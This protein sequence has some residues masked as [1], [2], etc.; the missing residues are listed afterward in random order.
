MIG[1]LLLGAGS[2]M[3]SYELGWGRLIHYDEERARVIIEINFLK[4]AYQEGLQLWA[5]YNKS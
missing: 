3:L 4:K 2:G 5:D 1:V